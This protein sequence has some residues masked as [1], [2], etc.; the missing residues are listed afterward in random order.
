MKIVLVAAAMFIG[1]IANADRLSRTY[2]SNL[3]SINLDSNLSYEFGNIDVDGGVVTLDYGRK[4]AK[5]TL[6]RRFDC[7]PNVHCAMVM[8]EPITIKLKITAQKTDGCGSKIVTA[9]DFNPYL[10]LPI[11][12]N[13]KT[14][15][16]K[17]NRK[18]YCELPFV[19][20]ATVVEL[21]TAYNVMRGPLFFRVNTHSVM[22]GSKLIRTDDQL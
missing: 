20:P 14:L 22:N 12:P 2:E 10:A 9:T 16:V 4:E 1:T 17:D 13:V 11:M 19:P 21:T 6:Y 7:P 3:E 18:F 8:P 15:Q 5:L